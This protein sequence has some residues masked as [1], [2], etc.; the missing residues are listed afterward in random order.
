MVLGACGMLNE[1]VNWRTDAE[2]RR[3]VSTG[4]PKIVRISVSLTDR[5]AEMLDR[6]SAEMFGGRERVQSQTVA[7]LV[8]EK[9]VAMFGREVMPTPSPKED[10][11]TPQ[12]E[13]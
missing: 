11:G 9:F 2:R 1:C 7:A 13:S 12:P 10:E 4:R 6:I 8:R 3:I 5:E